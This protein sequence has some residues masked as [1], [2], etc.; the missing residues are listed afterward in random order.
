M[1]VSNFNKSIENILAKHPDLAEFF[2]AQMLRDLTDEMLASIKEVAEHSDIKSIEF[3]DKEDMAFYMEKKKVFLGMAVLLRDLRAWCKELGYSPEKVNLR[4]QI[5]ELVKAAIRGSA[6]HEAGHAVIDRNPM[7][8]GITEEEWSQFGT[9]WLLNANLDRRVNKRIINLV[10]SKKS[11]LESNQRTAVL[12]GGRLTPTEETKK[13]ILDVNGFMHLF[14]AFGA[15]LLRHFITGSYEENIDPRVLK[16][17]EDE[18]DMIEFLSEDP[19]CVPGHKPSEVEVK[20]KAKYVYRQCL[21]MCGRGYSELIKRDKENQTIHQALSLIG[22]RKA[23]FPIGKHLENHID[24]AIATAPTEIV[25]EL[26]QKLAEQKEKKGA[27]DNDNL[28]LLADETGEAV[29]SVLGDQDGNPDAAVLTE[30]DETTLISDNDIPPAAEAPAKKGKKKKTNSQGKHDDEPT[31]FPKEYYILGPAILVEELS[32]P[33]REWLLEKFEEAQDAGAQDDAESG[34]GEGDDGD[35]GEGEGEEDANSDEGEPGK[36][37]KGKGKGKGKGKNMVKKLL[38]DPDEALKEKEDEISDEIKPHTLPSSSPSHEDM[39]QAE[40]EDPE[41][42]TPADQAPQENGGANYLFGAGGE[43]PSDT[44]D[45]PELEDWLE[46][47]IDTNERIRAWREAIKAYRKGGGKTQWDITSD[48]DIDAEIQNNIKKKTGKLPDDKIFRK[49]EVIQDKIA[50]SVLWRTASSSVPDSMK[51]FLF[52]KR[53]YEDTEIRKY[54]DLE[55]LVSQN[56]HGI[57]QDED[58]HIPIILPFGTDPIK[59]HE[60]IIANLDKVLGGGYMSINQDATAVRTQRERILKKA[61]PNVRRK[62]AIDVWD[63]QAVQAGSPNPMASVKEE[64]ATTQEALKG[65]GFCIVINGW[66]SGQNA[67][68]YGDNNYVIANNTLEVIQYLDIVVRNMIEYQDDYGDH[69]KAEV[70]STKGI[71]L[72]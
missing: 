26:E 27:S 10:P 8:L 14:Q 45:Y 2:D 55:I 24:D 13:E 53:L 69:I 17:L 25:E 56:V 63:E 12:P 22:L 43:K 29:Q 6:S 58:G 30:D 38:E 36:P 72:K 64:I 23:D 16:V 19:M 67:K 21:D 40:E 34:E 44:R 18:R 31:R 46:Q 7:D 65:K 11:D 20:E 1:E 52:L 59:D 47:N 32:D 42:N 61:S 57:A 41:N 33:L 15:N 4:A 51:L 66:G 60:Q 5:V 35:E 70:A 3:T 50:V 54:L 28:E 48:L 37:S 62:I 49:E 9:H 39:A 68:A 71:K